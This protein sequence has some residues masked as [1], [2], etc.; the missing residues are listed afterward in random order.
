MNGKLNGSCRWVELL[1][2]S[3]VS[4]GVVVVVVVLV[5]DGDVAGLV[6]SVNSFAGAICDNLLLG[7]DV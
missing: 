2:P 4:L 5:D 6:S 1:S 7:G 3:S